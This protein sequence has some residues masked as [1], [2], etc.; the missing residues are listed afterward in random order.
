MDPTNNFDYD[1]FDEDG[2]EN[3]V[4]EADAVDAR[5][6]PINQ[7]SVADF[8]INEEVLL[9]QGEA[10]HMSKFIRLYIGINGNIME[11]WTRLQVSTH[12]CTMLNFQTAL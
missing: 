6:K 5:G 11:I 4:P 12:L 7:Q 10:H 1:E 3:I 8:L 9:T 2:Y